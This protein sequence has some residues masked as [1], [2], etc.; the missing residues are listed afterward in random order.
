MK[1]ISNML[2]LLIFICLPNAMGA[3]D[4]AVSKPNFE[5]HRLDY[6]I[7]ISEAALKD[8]TSLSDLYPDYE[9]AWVSEYIAVEISTTYKGKIQKVVNKNELLSPAQK[10]LLARGDTGADIL[11]KVDYMPENTLTHNEQKEMEFRVKVLPQ[12][13]AQYPSGE[14]ALNRYLK[15][16]TID[17]IPD[18]SFKGYDLT[19]IKFIINEEG[20]VEDARVFKSAYQ[21][22]E[23]KEVEALLLEAIQ[24][25]NCWEP[26][27]YA[28]GTKAK[29]EFVF[30]VGNKESCLMNV[31]GIRNAF[32]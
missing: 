23:N 16:K 12:S 32:D 10:E 8:V 6:Y 18:N 24:H 31:L 15:E 19:A 13:D 4:K 2:L 11:V 27:E 5:V 14:E 29:Q 22:Y 17:K 21:T 1:H 30:T 3:Q 9:A 25:M 26:A 28:D 20:A 7:S